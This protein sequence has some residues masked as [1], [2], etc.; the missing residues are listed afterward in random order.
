MRSLIVL[1]VLLPTTSYAQSPYKTSWSNDG[2][3]LGVGIVFGVT[4]LIF[5][6]GIQPLSAQDIAGLSRESLNSFDRSATFRY[7]PSI[8]RTSDLFYGAA[9]IA[10]L[11]LLGH[12]EIRDDWE[13]FI[14]MYS[15][16]MM[17]SSSLTTFAKGTVR[18]IRPYVYNPDVPLTEK[19]TSDAQRSFFS[20]HTTMAFSS[21]VFFSTV[22]GDYF[23]QSQ[24]RPYI[25]T[26]SLLAAGVTGYLRYES[27]EHFPTDILVGAIVGSAIGYLVPVLH[28]AEDNHVDL[29]PSFGSQPRILLQFKI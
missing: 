4:G 9:I 3:V 12:S 21:A 25:W 29:M 10:P 15:E 23:P 20:G 2:P 6:T 18:R 24:W 22:Y 5:D 14:A 7:S 8:S 28:K 16:T 27:G 19:A 13:T 1:L 17:L 26:G 11:M